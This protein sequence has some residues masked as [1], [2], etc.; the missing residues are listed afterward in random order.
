MIRI[1]KQQK[2]P[3]VLTT[4]GKAKRRAMSSAYSRASANYDSGKKKFDFDKTI[5]GHETVKEALIK[6]Q[7]GKCFLCE[8]KVTHISYGDVEHFRPKGGFRQ[9]DSDALGKPG[10]YWLAYEWSN[11]FFVCQLCNQRFKKN[12]FPLVDSTKRAKSHHAD[13]TQEEPL[14]INPCDTHQDPEDLISFRAEIPYAINNDPKG[15]ATI[16]Y[17]GLDRVELNEKR[18]HYYEQLRLI[19]ALATANPPQP[20]SNDAKDFL[21]RAVQDSGEYASMAK[22]AIA[23]KFSIV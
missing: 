21:S 23:A 13:I 20:E 15:K 18:K 4:K 6:S 2:P 7:Q 8:S 17:A 5:Y 1:R 19:Y 9:S 16:K 12:F 14:F 11:L 10:Y 3:N 22:A